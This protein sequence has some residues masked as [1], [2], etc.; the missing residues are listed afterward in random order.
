MSDAILIAESRSETGDGPAKRLR[1]GGPSRLWSTA[2]TPT[3][4]RRG[5][6]PGARAHPARRSGANTLI[7]LKV[8]GDEPAHA[9][10]PGP[11]PPGEGHAAA[12]RL[13]PGARRP[14]DRGRGRASTSSARPRR[15][16]G[17][18]ARA[19]LFSLTV[20]AQ[21][22]RH[23][24]RDRARRHRARARRPLHVT[25]PAAARRRRRRSRTPRARRPC[26]V[27]RR[28]GRGRR[29]RSRAKRAR[30]PRVREAAPAAEEGG[31][32]GSGARTTR[33]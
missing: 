1:A 29:S 10:P 24:E 31:D 23:P 22:G 9:R 6:R 13:R 19:D 32:D 17:R 2:S 21:A 3:P 11:A 12:R 27:P 15:P 4:S 20:E 33:R 30:R 25:R 26:L 18:P 14:D 16:R 8:D 28:R 7:T 5:P